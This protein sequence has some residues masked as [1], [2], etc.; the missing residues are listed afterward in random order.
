MRL[1]NHSMPTFGIICR[2]FLARHGYLL[3]RVEPEFPPALA[4]YLQ[5]LRRYARPR[6]QFVCLDNEVRIQ[7]ELLRVFP[8]AQVSFWSPIFRSDNGVRKPVSGLPPVPAGRFITAVDLDAFPLDF[9]EESLPWLANAEAL[10]L[11]ARLGSFWAGE[12][13]LCRL[14]ARVQALGFRLAEVLRAVGASSLQA[15]ADS[16]MV[17]WERG[18]GIQSPVTLGSRYRVNEALTWLNRPIVQRKD[19][20]LLAG[21]GSF[22]FA[23]G[24][25]NPGAILEQGQVH[26][27]A[28]ADRTPWALQKT[29]E[30]LFFTSAQPLLLSLNAAHDIVTAD[31]LVVEGLPE[32]GRAEDFRLF[33]FRDQL[34]ANHTVIVP[35]QP[36]P[37]ARRP[38]RL[39]SMQTRPGLSRLDL[40]A[41]RLTW[42]GRPALDRPLAQ[43]E[44]NWVFF[45]DGDRL[46]L[47]YSF[48]PYVLLGAQNWPG[49]DFTTVVETRLD[50]PFDGDGLTLRNS[51]NPVDYDDDHW[52]HI[53]HK[54]Y[55]GKQYAFWAVLISKQTL[56]PVRVS[57]RPLVR[58]WH[59]A[60]ASIIYT[61]AVIVYG[62]EV[63]LFAGLDDSATAMATITRERLDAEWSVLAAR[64][65]QPA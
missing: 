14:A 44:K 5:S 36:R 12:L 24:V 23:A 49:L 17:V 19:F 41:K 35:P 55:P 57:A 38:L 33:K 28:K 42:L 64:E 53:V 50:L 45:T 21:R 31:P 46:L 58:G 47:L 10:L 40:P 29:D 61:C 60:S 15:P 63:S 8:A 1:N 62:V 18:G 32:P 7:S 6:L 2:Q 39:E 51:V 52:I 13:D 56:Q 22:G 20:Q 4:V 26:L 48:S 34:Y 3:A 11:R 37:A 65:A 16:V 43:T 59:S 54:V 25:Y 30:A 27:L 9:L